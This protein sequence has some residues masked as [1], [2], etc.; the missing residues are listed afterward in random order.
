MAFSNKFGA[1]KYNLTVAGEFR[2]HRFQESIATNPTF[3]FVAPRFIGAYGEVVFPINFF[4]DGRHNDGQ[5]DLDVARSFFK[6]MRMPD[7]FH[8]ASKP[9]GREGVDVVF[10]AHP[11]QPGTNVGGVNN[12][13]PDPTSAN[14]STPCVSYEHFI[15]T[16]IRGLYPNPTGALRK[17]LNFNL[18]FFHEGV[19]NCTQVFPYGKDD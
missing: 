15:N 2:F 6:D 18:N 9:S 1:G 17:A 14:L 7:D 5:L 10:A 12:F 11:I 13:V 8:R 3:S 4:I 19:G 16:T